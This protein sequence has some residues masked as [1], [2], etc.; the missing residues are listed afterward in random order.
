MNKTYAIFWAALGFVL[1]SAVL[2]LIMGHNI[3]YGYHLMSMETFLEVSLPSFFVAAA[4]VG[5]YY[6]VCKRRKQ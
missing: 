2:S 4:A 5:I 1:S 3:T 6:L